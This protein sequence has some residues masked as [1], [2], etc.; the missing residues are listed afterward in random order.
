MSEYKQLNPNEYSELR[1]QALEEMRLNKEAQDAFVKSEIVKAGRNFVETKRIEYLC[2][3]CLSTK[4]KNPTVYRIS[5]P[6]CEHKW[7]VKE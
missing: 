4:S 1:R 3:K 5:K 7:R 2:L 6:G